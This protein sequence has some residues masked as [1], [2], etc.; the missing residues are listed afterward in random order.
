MYMCGILGMNISNEELAREAVD[1]FSYRGPDS[2]GI[3]SDETVTLG[4]KRLAIIDLDSR[5]NQPMH[6][7]EQGITIVFNGEIYN[8]LDLKAELVQSYSFKTD[9]DT[10]VLLSAYKRWGKD[11]VSHVKGMY[12]FCIYD[13]ERKTFFLGRDYSGIKPLYYYHHE[14]IFSVG[15]RRA[16]VPHGLAISGHCLPDRSW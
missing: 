6:D 8:Y 10:E 16:I 2:T 14:G 3:F 12:A 15:Q 11:M 1:L 7:R 13:R 4:F 9:S 5:S